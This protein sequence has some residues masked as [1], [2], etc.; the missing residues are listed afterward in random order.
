M[1]KGGIF[2]KIFGL[3][4][5]I[6]LITG[7]TILI[8]TTVNQSQT[9]ENS[10]VEKNKL[11]AEIAVKSIEAGYLNHS[12]PFETLKK[13]SDSEEIVFL[14]I[15]RSGGEIFFADDPEMQGK[16]IK[17]PV[18]AGSKAVIVNR[19]YNNQ[20]IKL[21]AHPLMIKA[22]QKQWN[23]YLGAS[24]RTAEIVKKK[25]ITNGIY[26]FFLLI[27][28]TGFAAFYFSRNVI[29][30]IERLKE[31]AKIIGKGDFEHRIRLKTGDEIE[32]LSDGFNQMADNL[33]HFHSAIEESKAVLEIKVKSRTRELEELTLK[34]E[35]KVKERTKE[36]VEERD[37]VLAIINNLT[38]GLMVFDKKGVI[39]SINPLVEKIFNIDNN[40]IIGK[41]FKDLKISSFKDLASFIVQKDEIRQISRKEISLKK[42]KVIEVTTI[43]LIKEEQNIGFLA[44]LHDISREKLIENLKT[45][46]VSLTAHQ[47]RTP[48]SAIKWTLKMLMDGDFGELT[49]E[50]LEFIKKTY[51]SNERMIH[52]INDLLNLAR[53]EEGRYVFKPASA[54][55]ENLVQ[56]IIV[57]NSDEI[58][59]KKIDLKFIKQE[60]QL[61]ELKIDAEKTKIAIQNLFDN[62][63]KYT[64]LKGKITI[65]LK[66]NL[67]EKEA[68]FFI[69]DTGVGIPKNQQERVF[70]KFFRGTNVTKIETGGTGL[71]LFIAKNI[72]ETQGGKIWFE[73][74]EGKGSTFYFSLPLKS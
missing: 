65:I 49:P 43:P 59:K 45:E 71:G 58:K 5:G 50:Q 46:F 15:I 74:R 57:S 47:L 13:I 41:R 34:L 23:L 35:E 66:K 16:I 6:S 42:G 31:G 1:V 33:K 54:N 10:L 22:D 67:E 20:K 61:P 62:A 70:S 36:A 30:P 29:R 4:M 60:K 25:I 63:L 32:E 52:L 21:I 28:I 12:W 40:T 27:F 26:I 55:L 53:I 17:E 8:I 56:E 24:L 7:M 11:L 19:V 68:V 14:W 44:V 73:S 64:P 69:E 3:M 39:I 18:S 2:R 72:I 37:K 9:I 48:L 38:D 51:Q